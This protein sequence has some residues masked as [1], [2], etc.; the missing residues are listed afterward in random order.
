MYFLVRKFLVIKVV[1]N[2]SVPLNGEQCI[3][4]LHPS[5]CSSLSFQLLMPLYPPQSC[6]LCP[7]LSVLRWSQISS[8]LCG[9]WHPLRSCPVA[10]AGREGLRGSCLP[11]ACSPAL[12]LTAP[13]SSQT[14]G[15]PA[16][17][18]AARREVSAPASAPPP[19]GPGKWHIAPLALWA[20]PLAPGV[21]QGW[22]CGLVGPGRP[23]Q[24]GW[25]GWN[26]AVETAILG[27][28]PGKKSP[29]AKD[30]QQ[31]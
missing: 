9:K 2:L 21:P 6:F 27:D 14:L 26:F 3:F 17:T 22:G 24:T 15:G 29:K 7:K 19:T 1:K 10:S 12:S 23:E 28:G 4:L 25:P 18:S 11:D 30:N 5:I 31:G 13:A 8:L 16:E 20:C